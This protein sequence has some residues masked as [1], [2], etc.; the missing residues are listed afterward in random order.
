MLGN[1]AFS[2]VEERLGY[3]LTDADKELWDKFHCSN[4]DL[5]GKESGFHIFDIP[6]CIVFRGEDAKNAILEMFT[7][8]K[9]TK[10]IGTFQVMQQ[11]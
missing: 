10:S 3:K 11:S 9:I 5:S 2:Q 1:T 8:D 4:A 6:T 7:P